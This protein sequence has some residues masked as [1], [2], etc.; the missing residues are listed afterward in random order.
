MTVRYAWQRPEGC[1]ALKW[2]HSRVGES[3]FVSPWAAQW[4][5]FLNAGIHQSRNPE[6]VPKIRGTSSKMV[7][8]SEDVLL[9]FWDEISIC[10]TMKMGALESWYDKPWRLDGKQLALEST[11]QEGVVDS[12]EAIPLLISTFPE[13]VRHS[14]D[15]VSLWD[16]QSSS[17]LVQSHGDLPVQ[18]ADDLFLMQR[19]RPE[20][21]FQPQPGLPDPLSSLAQLIET[22]GIENCPAVIV[23]T[24]QDIGSE[25]PEDLINAFASASSIVHLAPPMPLPVALQNLQA[26]FQTNGRHITNDAPH[27]VATWFL[28]HSRYRRCDT[29][30]NVPLGSEPL[31]WTRLI[32]NEWRDL[33]DPDAPFQFLMVRPNPHGF[34]EVR[35]VRPHIIVQQNPQPGDRSIVQSGL[36][37]GHAPHL[38]H[39]WAIVIPMIASK[40]IFVEAA[41]FGD[42][43]WPL[44]DERRCQIWKGA[45]FFGRSDIIEVSAGDCYL[46]LANE[47]PFVHQLPDTAGEEGEDVSLMQVSV[48]NMPTDAQSSTGTGP[49]LGLQG[50]PQLD[51]CA[52]I[53]PEVPAQM[54]STWKVS[55]QRLLFQHGSS[56]LV[57]HTW[58]VDHDF[59]RLCVD[60][61]SWEV[62]DEPFTWEAQLRS[63]WYDH[64]DPLEQVRFVLVN[65]QPPC[66]NGEK[67]HGHLLVIQGSSQYKAVLLTTSHTDLRGTW[68][69]HYAVS[70]FHYSSGHYLSKLIGRQR[71]CEQS[72]CT[73]WLHPHRLALYHPTRLFDGAGIEVV[74]QH[75]TLSHTT[76]VPLEDDVT[77]MSFRVLQL[78][79][80]MR[81]LRTLS[82]SC[83]ICLK[84]QITNFALST[85][86]FTRRAMATSL[87]GCHIGS[88]A[89]WPYRQL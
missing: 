62:A 35:G 58:F 8:F 22:V 15:H 36:F 38:Y 57:F 14:E 72:V 5:A 48:P 34:E 31:R 26:Y 79:H 27:V 37:P 52:N 53:L 76:I 61:K 11:S 19:G 44:Q 84:G 83:T 85:L 16:S 23:Q 65:P 86:K 41:N 70:T 87:L 33:L 40:Q 88:V 51:H 1:A 18:E 74:V 21:G 56:S 43:C 45:Q 67:A 55:I 64:I 63:L 7:R 60:S 20:G 6:P 46:L 17:S 25:A 29:L 69:S 81:S 24:A 47:I 28:D 68:F 3:D 75:E 82:R 4:N 9:H 49:L 42:F 89:Y 80:R 2:L 12:L 66:N 13:E 32:L 10:T 71:D 50:E 73:V 78:V 30:R 54:L 59:V 39:H 77:S